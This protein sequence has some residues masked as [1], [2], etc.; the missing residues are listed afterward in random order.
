LNTKKEINK[1]LKEGALLKKL[2]HPNIQ[3]F[4]HTFEDEGHWHILLEAYPNG[5]L[6]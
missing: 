4:D 2:D 6:Q 3:Q 5:D 1:L